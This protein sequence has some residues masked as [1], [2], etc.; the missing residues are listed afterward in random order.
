MKLIHSRMELMWGVLVQLQ[1]ELDSIF[2]VFNQKQD[3]KCSIDINR[4]YFVLYYLFFSVSKATLESQMSVRLSHKP[5]SLSELLL[6][7]IKP[8]DH[9][10]Y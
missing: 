2:R 5:I 3:P 10:A 8:I 4:L 9:Q 1:Q 7:T 6:S